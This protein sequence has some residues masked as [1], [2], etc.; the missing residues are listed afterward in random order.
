MQ[1]AYDEMYAADGSVRES[2]RG[3]ADWLRATTGDLIARKREEA[4]LAFH[5]VGITF[6][7]Y[8]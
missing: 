3:Y 6:A 8:G 2:Y 1:T 5:R 4:E 7:V